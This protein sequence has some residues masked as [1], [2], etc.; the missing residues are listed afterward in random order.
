MRRG[1]IALLVLALALCFGASDVQGRGEDWPRLDEVAHGEWW[2]GAKITKD[3]LV[4]KVVLFVLW[5]S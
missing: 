1:A 5:G 3:D 4:G 2:V